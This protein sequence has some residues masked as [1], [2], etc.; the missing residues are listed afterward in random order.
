MLRNGC[1]ACFVGFTCTWLTCHPLLC[2]DLGIDLAVL[3][4]K[5]APE[6]LSPL[7]LGS[8]QQATLRVGQLC[9]AIG[10]PFG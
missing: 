4:I 9:L 7:M 2:C 1:E 6:S 8:S 10:N 3:R 5:A